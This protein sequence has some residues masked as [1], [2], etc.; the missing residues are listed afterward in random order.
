VV[1][2]STLATPTGLGHNT[3][4]NFKGQ[5]MCYF[6]SGNIR[7]LL[8]D[9]KQMRLRSAIAQVGSSAP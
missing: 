1:N 2:A 3:T 9:E 5:T 6:S 7:R 4:G 8:W